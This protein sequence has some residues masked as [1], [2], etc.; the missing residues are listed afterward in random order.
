MSEV[1][2]HKILYNIIR[3]Q[4]NNNIRYLIYYNMNGQIHL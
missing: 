4:D 2:G 1:Y 3:I